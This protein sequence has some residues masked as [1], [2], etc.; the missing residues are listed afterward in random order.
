MATA[1]SVR[2]SPPTAFWDSPSQL[3]RTPTSL[4]KCSVDPAK[5]CSSCVFN[6]L[7]YNFKVTV[8]S[9][10]VKLTKNGLFLT[11]FDPI[12]FKLSALYGG[13]VGTCMVGSYMEIMT[14]IVL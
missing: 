2:P 4:S 1:S 9:E 12:E 3:K 6:D 5:A 14:H 13:Y 8:A 10:Q 11:D 7:G